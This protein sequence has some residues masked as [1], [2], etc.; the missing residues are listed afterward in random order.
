MTTEEELW[1]GARLY[2]EHGWVTIRSTA[3]WLLW[4]SGHEDRLRQDGILLS[5]L[6]KKAREHIKSDPHLMVEDASFAAL[7]RD[8]K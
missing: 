5:D 6:L 7:E 2:Q 3:G 1:E 8:S 4:D